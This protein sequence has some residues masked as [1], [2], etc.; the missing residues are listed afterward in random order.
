MKKLLEQ[1]AEDYNA[2]FDRY[3]RSD[4]ERIGARTMFSPLEEEY[5]QMESM[6]FLRPLDSRTSVCVHRFALLEF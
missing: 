3:A 4:K 5:R 6:G 2:N 1:C